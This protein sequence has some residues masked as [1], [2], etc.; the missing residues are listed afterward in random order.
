[1]IAGRPGVLT[2]REIAVSHVNQK[3]GCFVIVE[4]VEWPCLCLVPSTAAAWPCL[5]TVYIHCLCSVRNSIVWL[6]AGPFFIFS[7]ASSF[8]K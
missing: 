4:T 5:S 1:M 7:V 8:V 2:G 6:L 3:R